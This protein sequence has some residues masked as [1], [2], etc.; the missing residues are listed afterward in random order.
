MKIICIGRN[1]SEHAKELGNEIPEKPVIF[2][3]PDTAVLKGNDFYIP[4]FSNDIHYELEVVLKISKGGKY[5]RKEVAHKHYEEIS[6]GI[7]F[8][9]RDLQSELKSKG[10]PWELAKGFDG[11]A[12]VGNFFRKEDFDL[13][14]LQ[15]SLLKNKEEVQNG[16]TKDMIFSFDDIV[17]FASQYFTLRVGD[18]IFTGTPKGVGKVNENDILEAYLQDDKILDI[19]IL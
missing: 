15:F 7:D 16:N 6:L 19:R 17:A 9:A 1:Y 11:S 10:L 5:I 14:E 2:M 12:V 3:K 4:E 8:T 13:Q 18:L